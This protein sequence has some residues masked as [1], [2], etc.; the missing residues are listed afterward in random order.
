MET[1]PKSIFCDIDGCLLYHHGSLS[2]INDNEAVLLPGVKEAINEWDRKGYR[3]ILTTGRKESMR[4][5]TIAQ[6]AK[7]GIV[8]DFLLMGIGGGVRVL[9]NDFKPDS[10]QETAVAICL[11]RNKGIAELKDL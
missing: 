9:I 4:E 11:E 5:R 3:I 2:G 1:R 8:Y 6:L 7:A 10:K